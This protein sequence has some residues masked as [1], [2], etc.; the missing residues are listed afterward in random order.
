MNLADYIGNLNAILK[1]FIEN[2]LDLVFIAGTDYSGKKDF[3]KREQYHKIYNV[4]QTPNSAT[5]KRYKIDDESGLFNIK[6]AGVEKIP[7][8]SKFK[9]KVYWNLSLRFMS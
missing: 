5:S 1:A 9:G 3:V 8:E 2:T 7:L 4:A 6:R